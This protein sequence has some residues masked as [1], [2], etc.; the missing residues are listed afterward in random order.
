MTISESPKPTKT[1]KADRISRLRREEHRLKA[2]T[3][4]S[5]GP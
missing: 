1:R 4:R 3:I 5:V 2:R